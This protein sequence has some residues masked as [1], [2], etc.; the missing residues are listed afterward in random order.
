[1]SNERVLYCVWAKVDEAN[2][3][4]WTE[5]I[6]KVH[7]PDVL[8]TKH[9]VSAKRF[10]V[11]DGKGDGNFLSIYETTGKDKLQ[12]Y[13]DKDAGRL[14]DDHIKHFGDKIKLQRVVLEEVY[15][16]DA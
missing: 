11:V 15:S 16:L 9:F 1:M 6:D 14:R 2:E 3:K 8:S 4:E 7:F 13:F 12:E 5:Y 10:K